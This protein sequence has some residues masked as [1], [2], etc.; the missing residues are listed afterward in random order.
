VAYADELLL[1]LTAMLVCLLS[2]NSFALHCRNI[3]DRKHYEFHAKC[4][5]PIVVTQQLITTLHSSIAL[6]I[7]VHNTNV[8]SVAVQRAGVA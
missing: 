3:I 5:S 7:P 1:L 2:G 6:C 8:F 4:A